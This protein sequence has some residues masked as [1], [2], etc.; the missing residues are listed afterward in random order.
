MI[1]ICR[2]KQSDGDGNSGSSY[3][4]TEPICNE[5]L[6]TQADPEL[7]MSLLD[8]QVSPVPVKVTESLYDKVKMEWVH[9][10]QSMS[11][12]CKTSTEL[13]AVAS[14]KCFTA[15]HGMGSS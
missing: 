6:T 13:V 10:F 11:L 15:F 5:D 9:H 2:K 3:Q 7:H 12:A 8:H 1:C 14:D 4:C